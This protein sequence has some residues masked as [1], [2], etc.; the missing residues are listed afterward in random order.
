MWANLLSVS[1]KLKKFYKYFEC[2]EKLVN[3]EKSDLLTH[4][5]LSKVT[6]IFQYQQESSDR[7]RSIN[8]MKNRI[9]RLY[10]LLVKKA[11]QSPIV[12][13]AIFSYNV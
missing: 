3:L 5:M 1:L 9:D 4:E 13:R 2:I 7:R 8:T 6:K 11:G 12:W 10:T